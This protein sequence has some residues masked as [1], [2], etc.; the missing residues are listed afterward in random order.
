VANLA[1]TT[2]SGKRTFF[3]I[4]LDRD[5]DA[6][7]GKAESLDQGRSPTY[8]DDPS[9]A[10]V[11]AD[12]AV[13]PRS[14]VGSVDPRCLALADVV[15]SCINLDLVRA[16]GQTEV[17]AC[18]T[19]GYAAAMRMVGEHMRPGPSCASRARCRSGCPIA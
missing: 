14:V 2:R 18:P 6:G 10:R 9:L 7:R 15:V 8:A 19:D 16:P 5:D 12:A 11:I 17:L 4:G 13:E 1:R 3:V